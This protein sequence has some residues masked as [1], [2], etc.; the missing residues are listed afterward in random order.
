MRGNEWTYFSA[1]EDVICVSG[2]GQCRDFSNEIALGYELLVKLLYCLYACAF[3][4]GLLLLDSLRLLPYR[5]SAQT[6]SVVPEYSTL[7]L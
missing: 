1:N 6:S 4:D 7:M 2:R 5:R 3:A